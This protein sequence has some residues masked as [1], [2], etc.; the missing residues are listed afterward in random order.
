VNVSKRSKPFLFSI[1]ALALVVLPLTVYLLQKEQ[2][3]QNFAWF[4]DQSASSGCSS[5]GDAVINVSFTN[6][7][8][9]S[10]MAMNVVANDLQTGTFVNLGTIAAN[11]T[12]TTQIDTKKNSITSGTVVFNLTWTSG[13]SGTDSRSATYTAVNSCPNQ[14][15]TP[16][17]PINYC[18]PS[19]QGLCEWD[20]VSGAQGYNV[21][22]TQPDTGRVIQ[23]LNLPETASQS[24]F[25]MSPGINYQCSVIPT[26]ACGNG[27][28]ANATKVCPVVT[29]TPTPSPTP[30]PIAC[31][32]GNSKEG[33]CQWN[34][35]TGASTYN[36]TVQDITTGQNVTGTVN[37]P[38]TQYSFPDN[39]VDTYQCQVSATNVCGT[40]PQKSSPPSTCT[41]PSPTPSPS[42]TLTPT[43][44]PTPSPTPTPTPTPSPTPTP[45]PVP[46]ATP[47]PVVIVTVLT[48]P[49][50]QVVET[51]PGQTHTVVEQQAGQTQT[52][53]QPGP[54]QTIYITPK[55]PTPT[56]PPTGN[57]TPT[58]ILIGTST[59]LLLAGGLIFFIL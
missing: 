14:T 36:I 19:G 3:F 39:G 9:S 38:S 43:P 24:S 44:T 53:I 32:N 42:P 52:V 4:T 51:V 20:P 2:V 6:A 57:T 8:T 48:Q 28:P 1:F 31:I 27:T 11:A 45:T 47:T 18:P 22:I 12:K 26:N 15:P 17:P 54:T 55:A 33:V 41:S 37:A 29:P 23:S 50:Q 21:V 13:E 10:S 56:M 40:T 58:F 59:L 7:E 5:N 46:T 49:P 35:V 30:T 16:T 25:P 34:A